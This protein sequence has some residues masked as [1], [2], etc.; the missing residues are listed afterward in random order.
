MLTMS[1]DTKRNVPSRVQHQWDRLKLL[2]M[3][4]QDQ[5]SWSCSSCSIQIYVA[6]AQVVPVHI[7][8]CTHCTLYVIFYTL[9]FIP[10]A[11]YFVCKF[12]TPYTLHYI[13]Y[14]FSIWCCSIWPTWAKLSWW[15]RRCTTTILITPLLCQGLWDTLYSQGLWDILYSQGLSVKCEICIIPKVFHPSV[16]DILYAMFKLPKC[17]ILK[18]FHPSVRYTFCYVRYTL[19]YV[20]GLSPKC[21]MY[22]ILK[23]FQVCIRGMFNINFFYGLKV[24][25]ANG[26]FGEETWSWDRILKKER[27]IEANLFYRPPSGDCSRLIS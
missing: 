4:V 26:D 15:R 21:E 7:I 22:F 12:Y 23:V 16:W 18:V 17:E 14:I 5:W 11:I 1:L 19:C 9:R 10:Y 25:L 20:Q 6:A 13:L 24:K 8:L 27:G 2:N 3:W